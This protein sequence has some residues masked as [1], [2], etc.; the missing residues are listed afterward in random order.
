MPASL[1]LGAVGVPVAELFSRVEQLM[2]S[3]I[4]DAGAELH[5]DIDPP[6]L[7][8]TAD[9]G[10]VEQVLINLVRN[11][12]DAVSAGRRGRIELRAHTDGRGRTLVDVVDDG[13]GIIEE[14]LDK[15]F[16]PFFTTRQEGS[17]IGLS[18]CR[19]VMRLHGG[20]ITAR[21]RPDEKTVF[22]LRF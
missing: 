5:I 2:A 3:Q 19:Q 8:L 15:I 10:L 16:I 9:S 17:G 13:P 4:R 22:S 21:S 6:T 18:L 12:V 1:G 11:A 20:T 14:A 7:E